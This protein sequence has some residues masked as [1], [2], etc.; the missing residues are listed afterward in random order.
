M[1]W[2]IWFLVDGW[3]DG[4]QTVKF[5]IT[6][7]TQAVAYANDNT[8]KQIRNNAIDF[9]NQLYDKREAYVLTTSFRKIVKNT[10][11]CALGESEKYVEN[12]HKVQV[13]AVLKKITVKE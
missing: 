1:E 8:D 9:A 4:T 12:M 11:V 13:V 5:A 2:R 7:Q 6:D 3:M 10:K